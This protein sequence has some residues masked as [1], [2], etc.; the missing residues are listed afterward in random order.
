[1]GFLALRN[2]V[3]VLLVLNQC[4]VGYQYLAREFFHRRVC[5]PGFN[6]CEEL[7]EFISGLTE[8]SLRY[9]VTVAIITTL[10][11][12]FYLYLLTLK[13][14]TNLIVVTL[15]AAV[16]LGILTLFGL[17]FAPIQTKE[18]MSHISHSWTAIEWAKRY[19]IELAKQ[20]LDH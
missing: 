5:I 8:E 20:N 3:I 9:M 10:L 2:T 19:L 7:D 15:K 16:F 17:Y 12:L 1:M 6:F 18:V 4:V 14:I 11:E 13:I